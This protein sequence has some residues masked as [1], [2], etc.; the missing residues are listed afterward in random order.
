M[1]S[2]LAA[3]P[4]MSLSVDRRN[5]AMRMYERLGFEVVRTDGEHSVVM[6]HDSVRP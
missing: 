3:V 2:L 1:D 6:L 5:P 4:R